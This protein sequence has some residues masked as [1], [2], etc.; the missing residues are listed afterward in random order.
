MKIAFDVDVIKDLGISN[1]VRQVAEWG[2]DYIEQ[3]PHPQLNPFYKHPK[4]GREVVAEY[5]KVL[6]ETG[7]QISSFIVVYRWAG[8]LEAR[9]QA[10]V[11]NWKRMI[12]IAVE[13]GVSVI[14]T[15]LSGDPNEPEVCEE[16]WYRSMEELL[17]II[18]REGIRVEIQSHPWDFCEENNETADLVK[19]LRSDNVKYLYSVPHTFFY[20]KGKGDVASMLKYAGDDL[21]HV[22]IADTMNHTKHCRYIVNP[23]GVDAVIHQHVG[24]GDG[25]VDFSALF[26]TLRDMDFANRT[27]KVGGESIIATS[28]FGYPEKMVH[29]AVATRERIKRELLGR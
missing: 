10:A 15:E 3:S 22:L 20:D 28:L 29:Q 13:M 24:I 1:M 27:F 26:Q 19:S 7:V 18:E 8:P 16:M 17:P 14:N 23:P 6:K 4:A 21:S 5:K 11:T 9:R 2:Y 25:E 12:E